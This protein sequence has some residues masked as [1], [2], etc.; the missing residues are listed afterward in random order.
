MN[1]LTAC[2]FNIQK[3]SLHDGP[4]IR[5]V[6]F[7][8]GCPL[9]CLWCS[10]PESQSG[11]PQLI[12]DKRKAS[13]L[14][15]GQTLVGEHRTLDYVMSEVMKDKDFYDESKGGVTLSGGEVLQQHE[16]A[17]ALL[18]RLKKLDIH[19]AC[20]TT[21]YASPEIFL[22][23]IED[24]DLILFDIKHYDS[25]KHY[26]FTNVYNEKIILN[27]KSAINQGKEIIIR[28]PVIPGINNSLEDAISG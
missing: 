9:R 20:E 22:A 18:K 2:L 1:K 17:I 15:G 23:F 3:Y 12:L 26:A 6:V 8:K 13:T 14:V 5:T 4:G 27:L 7:F 21:G 16:F 11:S 19:T 10:N 28:I 25:Q 24:I